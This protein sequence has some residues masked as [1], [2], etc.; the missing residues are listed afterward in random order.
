MGNLEYRL[1]RKENTEIGDWIII[2]A[3][4]VAMITE[5]DKNT[6]TAGAG[7]TTHQQVI[8]GSIVLRENGT[9]TFERGTIKRGDFLVIDSKGVSKI[10]DKDCIDYDNL[11][12]LH[13]TGEYSVGENLVKKR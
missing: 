6:I 13:Q 9:Y 5:V 7:T 3:T 11:I 2:E 4:N 8:D 12:I 10:I 1:A